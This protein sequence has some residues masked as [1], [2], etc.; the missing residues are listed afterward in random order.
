MAWGE[1]VW[2]LSLARRALDATPSANGPAPPTPPRSR[3]TGALVPA[4]A[5]DDAPSAG[6][7]SRVGACPR[8]VWHPRIERRPHHIALAR[9]HGAR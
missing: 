6:A 3:L 9:A 8:E 7:C 4:R 1:G 2:C 5:V